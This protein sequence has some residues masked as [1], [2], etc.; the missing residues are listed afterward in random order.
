MLLHKCSGV[1]RK[2]VGV[3]FD[4]YHSHNDQLRACSSTIVS[5][6]VGGGVSIIARTTNSLS[7][8]LSLSGLWFPVQKYR[9]LIHLNSTVSPSND[10]VQTLLHLQP[11]FVASMQSICRLC[12]S[13]TTLQRPACPWGRWAIM[14]Y[15][16]WRRII[17]TLVLETVH[18]IIN[19]SL[20]KYSCLIAQA[21]ASAYI[22]H[23][24]IRVLIKIVM[25]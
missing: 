23:L 10:M 2:Y 20:I 5:W 3:N 15:L 18:V 22:L 8:S 19:Q 4:C 14:T 1:D 6:A 9:F 7:L 25:K 13:S 21:K 24:L 12:R 17:T 16:S 11:M